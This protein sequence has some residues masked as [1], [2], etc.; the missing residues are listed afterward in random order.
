MRVV[1]EISG[2]ER[3]QRPVQGWKRMGGKI[4]RKK[5]LEKNTLSAL[6]RF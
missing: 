1:S 5:K 4:Q 6:K 2:A 3:I